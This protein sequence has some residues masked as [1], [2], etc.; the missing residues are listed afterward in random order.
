MT[1]FPQYSF[2]CDRCDTTAVAP[3]NS[4]PPSH[5]RAAAPE[6]WAT[7]TIGTDPGRPPHHLCPKCNAAFGFFMGGHA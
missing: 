5:A 7:I 1:S 3:M 6:G 2:K 4:A